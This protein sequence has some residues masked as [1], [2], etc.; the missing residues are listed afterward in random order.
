MAAWFR[1]RNFAPDYLKFRTLIFKSPDLCR[2][3]LIFSAMKTLNHSESVKKPLSLCPVLSVPVK[4]IN[5][6][7]TDFCITDSFA[8]WTKRDRQVFLL[9]E[10]VSFVTQ[11]VYIS[12]RYMSKRYTNFAVENL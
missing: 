12:M 10:I 7:L 4:S 6:C 5:S 3:Y 11:F 1:N 9:S 2:K 8:G